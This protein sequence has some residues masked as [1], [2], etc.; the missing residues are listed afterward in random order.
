MPFV[1]VNPKIKLIVRGVPGP[2]GDPTQPFKSVTFDTVNPDLPLNIAQMTW[3]EEEDTLQFRQNGTTLQIGQE[4]QWPVVNKTGDD[5]VN[6]TPVMAVGTTGATGRLNIAPMDGTDTTN[7]SF[8]G[9][10]ATE[11]I[12]NQANGKVSTFGKVR[13]IQTNGGQYGETWIDGDVIYISPTTIGALTNIEPTA[14]QVKIVCAFV[15]NSHVSDGVLAVRVTPIDEHKIPAD[16]NG[17]IFIA[18]GTAPA[19]TPTLGGFLYVEGGALKYK[20]S[21]GTI[22]TIAVA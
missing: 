6:G 2:P 20:G 13:D 16:G 14:E 15:I 4:V 17:V 22:T 11:D 5:I 8:F 1:T 12:D 19:G 9:G 21:S 10:L 3:D 7:T 18:N